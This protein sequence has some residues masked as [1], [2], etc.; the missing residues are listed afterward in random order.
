MPD[1]LQVY[2]PDFPENTLLLHKKRVA[3]MFSPK[4]ASASIV[5]WWLEQAGLLDCAMRFFQFSHDFETLFR[6]SREYVATALGFDPGRYAIYKF[7]RNPVKR[8]L[9]CFAHLLNDPPAFGVPLDEKAMSFM[10]FLSR[11]RAS[12]FLGD[13]HFAP[14][15]TRAEEL[16]RL[17]PV[18][19][20]IEDGLQDHLR[21]IESRHGLPRA[22]FERNPEINRVL[23]GHSFVGQSDISVRGPNEKV[24]FRRIPEY[25]NLLTPE[26][27][28]DIDSLYR[29]DFEAYGYRAEP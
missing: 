7:V 20:R 10:D 11:L 13:P 17:S 12:N 27:L 23:W 8:A 9:S 25:A 4:C 29:G 2:N 24:P 3:L 22:G 6:S 1:G 14:Q 16:G 5:Y 28:R 26:S 18:V 19:L 15:L 21:A